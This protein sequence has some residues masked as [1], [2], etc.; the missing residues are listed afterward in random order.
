MLLDKYQHLSC[1]SIF[2]CFVLFCFLGFFLVERAL[3]PDLTGIFIK[4][5]KSE[6]ES[7]SII[8]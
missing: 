4:E 6:N 8:Y 5:N 7:Q 2:V 3:F 1:M